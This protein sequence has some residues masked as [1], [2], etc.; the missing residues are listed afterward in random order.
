MGGNELLGGKTA[1]NHLCDIDLTKPKCVLLFL[2]LL[3]SC[4]VSAAFALWVPGSVSESH[5]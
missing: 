3:S 4:N 1:K 2:T 5:A